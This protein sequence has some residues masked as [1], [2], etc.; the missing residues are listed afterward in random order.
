MEASGHS[1][2]GQSAQSCAKL[3]QLCPTLCNPMDSSLPGTSVHGFSRQ[4]HRGE[5]PS[6]PPGDLP[7]PG[8]EPQ[9]LES[10]ALAGGFFTTSP[11]Q[12]PVTLQRATRDPRSSLCP[13]SSLGCCFSLKS[14]L[15]WRV[16]CEV[17]MSMQNQ[18]A[19][20]GG[21]F[22]GGDQDLV[23]GQGWASSRPVL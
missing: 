15:A 13:E 22:L 4:E 14:V 5:L 6:P 18:R 8:L 2:R 19:H 17:I 11:E 20:R 10:P 12:N 1:A 23:I 7:D 21:S 16:S 3:L 9:S